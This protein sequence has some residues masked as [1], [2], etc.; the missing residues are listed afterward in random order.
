MKL[1]IEGSRGGFDLLS[2]MFASGRLSTVLGVNVVDLSWS[3]TS[4]VLRTEASELEQAITAFLPDAKAGSRESMNRLFEAVYPLIRR[5]AQYQVRRWS[6]ATTWVDAEDLAMDVVVRVYRGLDSFRGTTAQEFIRWI[7]LLTRNL[8]V[9]SMRARMTFKRSATVDTD[10]VL[11]AADPSLDFVESM[12]RSEVLQTLQQAMNS[13]REQDRAI[14]MRYFL[15]ERPIREIALE[16]NMTAGAV[17]IR[18]FRASKRLRDMLVKRDV[19]S[20]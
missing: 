7:T 2:E 8:A 17:R 9:D 19:S 1:I 15:E 4:S 20:D 11:D 6:S 5:V 12:E 3:S 14:V 13:L 10:A 16:L 18:L